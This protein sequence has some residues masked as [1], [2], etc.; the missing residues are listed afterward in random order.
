LAERLENGWKLSRRSAKGRA[1]CPE[2]LQPGVS[3][4]IRETGQKSKREVNVVVDVVRSLYSKKGRLPGLEV[5]VRE[6]E[7]IKDKLRF[8][9][10][11]S[12]A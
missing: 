8:W 5:V 10:G 1:E 3:Y 6:Q 12:K 7:F 2:G 4:R 9:I 11:F